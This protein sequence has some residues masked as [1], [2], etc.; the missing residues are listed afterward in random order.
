MIDKMRKEHAFWREGLDHEKKNQGY[1]RGEDRNIAGCVPVLYD[2]LRGREGACGQSG[3]E[4]IC[5]QPGIGE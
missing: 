5:W 1:R 4:G 3:R 2:G